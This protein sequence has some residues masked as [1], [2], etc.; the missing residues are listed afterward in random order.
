M[1]VHHNLKLIGKFN[2]F[3]KNIFKSF[4][5][6]VKISQDNFSIINTPAY[7]KVT[8]TGLAENSIK[9]KT[10]IF[11]IINFNKKSGFFILCLSKF[12]YIVLFKIFSTSFIISIIISFILFI[13]I[14]INIF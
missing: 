12:I 1:F 9:D 3:I 4:Q 6:K 11:G 10:F 8:L 13:F 7:N 2:P 5:N 14:N